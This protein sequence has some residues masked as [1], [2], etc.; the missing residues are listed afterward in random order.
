MDALNGVESNESRPIQHAHLSSPA[1]KSVD[2]SVCVDA[3]TER[4]VEELAKSR[5]YSVDLVSWLKE[6]ELIG[7]HQG[8][9]AFPVHDHTGA[10]VAV[11]Y[12]VEDGSWRYCPQ[13]ASVQPLVIGKLVPGEPINLFESQWDAFALMDIA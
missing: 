9:I 12:R 6:H 10:V 4:Y 7:L 2:W 3:F 11:H 13:G 5:D 8:C 1:P